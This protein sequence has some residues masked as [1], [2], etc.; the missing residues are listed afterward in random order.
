MLSS[1]TCLLPV[2]QSVSSGR[3]GYPLLPDSFLLTVFSPFTAQLFFDFFKKLPL[4]P[5]WR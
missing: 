2:F 1:V 5:V 3:S 4:S